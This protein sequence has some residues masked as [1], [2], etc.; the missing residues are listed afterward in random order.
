MNQLLIADIHPLAGLQAHRRKFTLA[1]WA[2]QTKS[3]YGYDWR[4][5]AAWCDLHARSALPTSAD[6]VTLYLTGELERGCKVSTTRRRYYAIAYRHRVEGIENR[7]RLDAL[8]LLAGAQRLRGEKARQMRAITIPDLRAMSQALLKEASP[9]AVRDR[10]VLLLGFT[11]ALRSASLTAITLEDIEWTDRGLILTIPKEKQDQEHRGRYI[12]IPPG[13]SEDTCA[14]RALRG[15]L[16][17]RRE[18]A[19]R[20][21][22]LGVANGHKSAP[23]EAENVCRIVKR[24]V[25]KIGLDPR[26][27]GAHSLRAGLI[28]EAGEAGM[29]DLLIADHSGHHDMDVLRRYLRRTKLFRANVC[30]A[31]DL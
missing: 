31:L 13:K 30:A 3:G 25:Q 20:R 1:T 16:D 21:V 9:M 6:T 24:N 19:T 18:V 22:F 23:M 14:I 27:Y 5:F 26:H 12:G 17:A 15:W 8:N 7:A 29:S 2:M 28:T 11:S 10:A 4:K